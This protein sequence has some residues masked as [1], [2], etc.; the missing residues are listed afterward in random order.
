ME[1]RQTLNRDCGIDGLGLKPSGVTEGNLHALRLRSLA[2]LRDARQQRLLAAETTFPAVVWIVTLFGGGVTIA[3]GSFLGFRALACMLRSV[4]CWR[5][6]GA[7]VLILII[8]LSNPSRGDFRVSTL[9]FDRVLFQIQLSPS[10][11]SPT[12]FE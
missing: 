3:F 8:A 2:R 10:Q 1:A 12:T 6:S 11:A 5:I 9:P 7:P 4:Q